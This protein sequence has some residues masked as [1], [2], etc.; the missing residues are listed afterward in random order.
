[1]FHPC[2][3]PETEAFEETRLYRIIGY[4]ECLRVLGFSSVVG[5]HLI[6]ANLRSANLR[7]ATLFSANLR[8]ATLSSA[9][10]SSANLSSANL[11]S[12][13][14]SSA[15]LRS[16]DLFSANLRSANL[17]S[18][19]LRSADLSSADLFRANLFSATLSSADLRSATL[20][21]ANLSSA[22]LSSANLSSANLSSANL[23]SANLFS[24]DLSSANLSSANL[25]SANLRSANLR[26][27]D[28]SSANLIRANFIRA[29]FKN[30]KW[31]SETSWANAEGIHAAENVPPVLAQEAAF[32]AALALSQGL[33]L[34][35]DGQ[36]PE[37]IASYHQA[38]AT[39]PNIDISAHSWNRLCWNGCLY[40]HAADVLYAG[41]KAV[42]FRSGMRAHGSIPEGWPKLLTNDLDGALADFQS[43][44]SADNN[45]QIF[46][47]EQRSRRERWVA[48][49]QSG[50]N[51]FTPEELAALRK[52][53]AI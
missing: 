13:N 31:N 29:N 22:N 37:A 17:R 34:A 40:G 18:A 7:S 53:E 2:G 52:A 5:K 23:S 50:Q 16:A 48:A 15:N 38:Q 25:S 11:F 46:S 19:N 27:A 8:S 26:S 4:S 51:P 44:L 24:A 20:S 6:S 42:K 28:L 36:I 9:N 3:E 43:A 45:S 21:S 1:M 41:E 32:A 35:K 49:L 33:A 14:L 10:L 47:D 30:I 39:D 12:A